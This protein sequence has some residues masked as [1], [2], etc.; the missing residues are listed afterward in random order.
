M[1]VPCQIDKKKKYQIKYLLRE[2]KTKYVKSPLYFYKM[3]NCI[4]AISVFRE[5]NPTE[6]K[7][8]A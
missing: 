5:K 4:I 3:Q 1:Q 8:L 6:P 2:V 7:A